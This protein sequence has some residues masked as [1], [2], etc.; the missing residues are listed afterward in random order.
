MNVVWTKHAEERL[1]EWGKK[2]GITQPEIE[3]LLRN[4]Q[5]IAPGDMDALVAQS[6]SHGGLWR[7]PFKNIKK[8]R[9][10]LTIYWTSKIEKYWKEEK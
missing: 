10:I 4:P 3:F 1:K 2:L 5:Q 8:G 6:K 9:K 7:I